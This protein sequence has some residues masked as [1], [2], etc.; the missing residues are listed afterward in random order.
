[1][2]APS[3]RT[4]GVGALVALLLP[5]LA[6]PRA[7]T[8][9]QETCQTFE[10]TGFEVCG[11]LLSFWN[12]NG[13]LPVFGYPI[14]TADQE[15]SPETG[16]EHTVQYFERERL[17]SHPENEQPYDVLLGRLGVQIL[18][19]TGRDWQSFPKMDP[20]DPNYFQETGFA[21]A[22]EFWDYWSSHGLEFGDPGYSFREALLLFGFPI[23]PPQMETN[24]DGD[25]VLTQ[26]FER[27][28]FEYHP[29]N[30]PEFQVLLGR[31]GAEFIDLTAEPG[32]GETTEIATALIAEGL[33]SPLLVS[34]PP[35]GSGRLYIVDQVGQIRIV[36][37]EGTL[38]D[39]PFLDISDRMVEL[40]LPYDERGLLGLAFHPDYAANGRFFIYYSAPLRASAPPAWAHTNV[41]VEFRVSEDPLRADPE[42]VREILA[43]DWPA[44]NHDG[45]TVAFGPE[46]GYLYLSLGDGGG[47]YDTWEGHV[48]D[49]YD[50]NAGG[51]G[52]DIE[53]N[54][55]GSILRIDVDVEDAPYGIPP[56]NPFVDGPGLDEIYAYGFRNPYRMSFD[57]G[58]DHRLFA[59]DAGQDLWEEVSI[60]ENGGNYGWNVYE[61]AHCFDAENPEIELA[62]CPTT[63]G[64]SHPAAGAPLIPPVLEFAHSE[65]EG[66]LGLT[67]VGGHV[68]RA[69]EIPTFEGRYIFAAWSAGRDAAGGYLP[70]RIF[71]ASEQ[72]EGLWG[73]QE[74][75]LTNMPG[76]DIGAFI[77]GF[78]QD[79][80]GHVYVTTTDN[81][82][83]SGT[84]GKVYRLV[85]G[86]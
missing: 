43:I 33:T 34:E 60:V 74:L 67:V 10:E 47:F 32:N 58:G 46:D 38:V 73:F 18:E 15:L 7:A 39:E 70:G 16:D 64:A 69:N 80:G 23:S 61:G 1:M 54:L 24:P 41:L 29:D 12:D 31:L 82:G 44:G 5:A 11:D 71:I 6:T 45:G 17:E 2:K 36:T 77:L 3:I 27:A 51:N 20:T 66:G 25:T 40:T 86:G 26:W 13:G 57:I 14:A 55:L 56:D 49:W 42:P 68:Y 4:L 48:D 75:T 65:Q 83:P 84:T 8:Q 79:L 37:P 30:A 63:V 52:Q 59:G 22:P 72:P 35:D 85:P 19:L 21:I 81:F 9:G 53:Q 78:G 76:G 62:D 28:R 50:F